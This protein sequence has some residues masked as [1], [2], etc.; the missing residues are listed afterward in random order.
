M[1]LINGD[2]ENVIFMVCGDPLYYKRTS[3]ASDA[4]WWSLH[5]AGSH[6]LV[7]DRDYL[8]IAHS[9]YIHRKTREGKTVFEIAAER[10]RHHGCGD[11]CE[12]WSEVKVLIEKND[13]ERWK[14]DVEPY[15]M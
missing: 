10:K 5:L 15:A 12:I 1:H 3:R 6:G 13:P 2:F 8:S 4:V 9:A 14:D 11:Y 7:R